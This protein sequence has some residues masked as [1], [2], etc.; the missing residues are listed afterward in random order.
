MNISALYSKSL[1]ENSF[2]VLKYGRNLN[3]LVT[4]AHMGRVT[5]IHLDSVRQAFSELCTAVRLILE[6]KRW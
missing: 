5:V 2:F 6:R 3:Q 1:S 4:L